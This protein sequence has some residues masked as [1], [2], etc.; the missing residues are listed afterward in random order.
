MQI[1]EEFILDGTR[2]D[3]DSNYC[4]YSVGF[5]QLDT[6]QDAWYFGTWVNPDTLTIVC[7]CEGDLITQ[8]ADNLDEFRAAVR[9]IREWNCAQGHEFFGID[10]GLDPVMKSKFEGFGMG[11]LLH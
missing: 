4:S 9:N 3:Y 7:Y 8:V 2:Y 6:S 10:P 11:D 1:T 5:A